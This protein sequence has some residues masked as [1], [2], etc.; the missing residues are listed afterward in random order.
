MTLLR[1]LV[2][3]GSTRSIKTKRRVAPE[4]PRAEAGADR[5]VGTV[6]AKCG[7]ASRQSC[8]ILARIGYV[9]ESVCMRREACGSMSVAPTIVGHNRG[10]RYNTLLE[11]TE[12]CRQI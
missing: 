9:G 3:L 2:Q 1:H 5:R 6:G 8:P 12:R 7:R 11:R 10:I 4:R